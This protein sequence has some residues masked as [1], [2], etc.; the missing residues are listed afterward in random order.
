MIEATRLE[1]VR[2]THRVF[3][4]NTVMVCNSDKLRR[5]DLFFIDA[6]FGNGGRKRY[7][8]QLLFSC[9]LSTETLN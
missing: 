7:R 1:V 6:D 8:C 4:S 2:L 9:F 3:E 5:M